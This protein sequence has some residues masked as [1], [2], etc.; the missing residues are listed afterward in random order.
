[1]KESFL[2]LS[3]WGSYRIY[4]DFYNKVIHYQRE[5]YAVLLGSKELIQSCQEEPHCSRVPDSILSSSYYLCAL[6][7]SMWVSSRV[8]S[9]LET[10]FGWIVYANLSLGVNLCV[11]PG[12]SPTSRS[13]TTMTIM[14]MLCYQ[15]VIYGQS[16]LFIQRFSKHE[17][18]LSSGNI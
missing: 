10:T 8:S 12:C 14:L 6:H 17:L 3:L 16:S 11:I 1:M 15:S 13:T 2:G 18:I 5:F 9:F 7:L 4:T